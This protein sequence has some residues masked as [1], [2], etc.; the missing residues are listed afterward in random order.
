M[1]PLRCDHPGK[2]GHTYLGFDYGVRKVGIA[3]GQNLTQ[4]ATSLDT[5]TTR[6]KKIN[7]GKIEQYIN[8]WQPCALVVGVPLDSAGKET[9]MS[10]R[11]RK[12]GRDL[13]DRYHL[14]VHWVNEYLTST[15][16]RQL[17]S[18][19]AGT[20]QAERQSDQ[21]AAKLILETFLNEQKRHHPNG[22]ANSDV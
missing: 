12:F 15:A 21:V 16:A 11:A 4:T 6:S 7:W 18:K 20:R 14:P 1:T 10:A 3:V 9:A 2:S 17:L 5:L 19:Q 22:G 8:T 13:S